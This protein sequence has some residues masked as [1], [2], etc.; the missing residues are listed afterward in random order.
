MACI[1]GGSNAL[2]LFHEFL[3]EPE[4]SKIAVEADETAALSNGTPGIM[5]GMKTYM[6]QTTD[7]S[8]SL[9]GK[10]LGAGIQYFSVGPQHSYLKDQGAVT[11]TSATDK[12]IL[13][14]YKLVAKTEGI[15]SALEPMAAAAEVIK[16]AK[17]KKKDFI[18][19]MNLCGRGEK[20]LETIEQHIG[21]DFD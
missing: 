14:A 16:Q 7:G 9:G 6:L 12:E 8:K 1:G 2:G 13:E 21:K 5:Q 11:Y 19:V 17:G 20:D 10:S 3:D 4:I 15:C 18:I